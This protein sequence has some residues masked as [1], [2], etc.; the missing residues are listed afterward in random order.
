MKNDIPLF[1]SL[2]I[3][4]TLIAVAAASLSLGR[5]DITPAEVFHALRVSIFS[6]GEPVDIPK[7][8]LTVVWMLRLPRIL[9][10]LIVG[11]AL[12]AA[13]T[14]FQGCFRNPL[15]E[16]YILGVSS[17]AAFGAALG[18]LFPMFFS[19]QLFAFIFAVLAV[20]CAYGFGR[21]RG[22]TPMITLILAGVIT[23]SL[24]SAMV[25]I[26]KYIAQD[27]ALRGIVFWLMG[28]FYY[29]TW[30]DILW[31][32]PL[33]GG[34]LILMGRLGWQ[35]NILS[36]GD[37]Q[38]WSLGLHAEMYRTLLIVLATL[39]TAAA[40]S[41]VGIIAWVGLM[42]PHAARMLVGYDNRRV[43]PAAAVMGGIFL[44]VCDTLARTLSTAEI[45][46]GIITS[47]AGAPY[48]FYLLRSKTR[49]GP[50]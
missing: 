22:E 28:G 16:P 18:M 19:V 23:G 35:L 29:A 14:V 17:G 7:L 10:A 40:V 13:G 31:L 5:Y 1:R 43:L 38:A 21:I 49:N 44:I 48:L 50:V 39:A 47:I 36:L 20:T 46:I 26:L 32:F 15:V 25:S 45:P 34:C 2:A 42:I 9:M 8:H 11:A 24:F 12:A 41:A 37:A 3:F 4:F 6:P 33:V 27:A 30:S